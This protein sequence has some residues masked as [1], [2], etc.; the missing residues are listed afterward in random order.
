MEALAIPIVGASRA[1]A[2][3]NQAAPDRR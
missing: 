3:V 2:E 1:K